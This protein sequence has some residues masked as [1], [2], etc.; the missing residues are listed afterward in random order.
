MT[1][2][3]IAGI[4]G[5]A[6]LLAVG[7][8]CENADLNAGQE[9]LPDNPAVGESRPGSSSELWYFSYKD[10]DSTFRI[11]WP[12]YFANVLGVGAGSY[13]TVNGQFAEFRG[14]DTDEGANRPSYS[15][16]GPSIRFVGEVLCILYAADGQA[17][18]WFR[19]PVASPIQGRL[20]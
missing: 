15:V 17:L 12:S 20:P 19:T 3:R 6:T 10:S 2:N 11:R 5:L 16:P 1:W 18:A 4:A 8:G 13:T 9:G 7:M 14:F